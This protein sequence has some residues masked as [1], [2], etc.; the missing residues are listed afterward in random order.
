MCC[1]EIII[2]LCQSYDIKSDVDRFIENG[3]TI[4]PEEDSLENE[5]EL[6]WQ[7]AKKLKSESIL[8]EFVSDLKVPQF[9]K[10]HL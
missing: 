1:A 5:F 4:I 6:N 9:T 10:K 8:G 2:F 3:E 7:V